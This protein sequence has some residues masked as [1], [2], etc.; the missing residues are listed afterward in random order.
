VVPASC[1]LWRGTHLYRPFW[2]LPTYLSRDT[3]RKSI[4]ITQVLTT[5]CAGD[6]RDRHH[7]RCIKSSSK[8]LSQKRKSCVTC[9]RSKVKCNFEKPSCSRCADRVVR[10][11]YPAA[12][13]A[14]SGPA[15]NSTGNDRSFAANA[16]DNGDGHMTWNG[17]IGGKL[18]TWL[19][20]TG[21]SWS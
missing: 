14:F 19:P 17:N 7:R 21:C 15:S 10:C 11:E 1:I 12:V 4:P 3:P 5:F 18:S 13:V 2:D 16:L 9:A 8:P 6:L 20:Q